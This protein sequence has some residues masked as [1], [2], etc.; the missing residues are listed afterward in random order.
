MRALSSSLNKFSSQKSYRCA[1]N[2]PVL[3]GISA[4][5]VCCFLRALQVLRRASFAFQVH[6]SRK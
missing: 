5:W 1:G 6:K 4:S 2:V 3:L